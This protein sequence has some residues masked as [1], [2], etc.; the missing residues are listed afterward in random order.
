MGRWRQSCQIHLEN[1]WR[2]PLDMKL[3]WH[4]RSVMCL[5][6][7]IQATMLIWPPRWQTGKFGFNSRPTVTGPPDIK[8][9]SLLCRG[10][11]ISPAWSR[12]VTDGTL[13]FGC[14][15]L[16]QQLSVQRQS[17]LKKQSTDGWKEGGGWGVSCRSLG[18]F[19]K[20]KR[21]IID[22]FFFC[23]SCFYLAINLCNTC[24]EKGLA[25]SLQISGFFCKKLII[26]IFYRRCLSIRSQ[27]YEVLAPIS[28]CVN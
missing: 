6:L 1:C 20:G 28:Y 12:C 22:K 15:L 26:L 24:P 13:D 8:K 21:A 4:G 2:V 23:Q 16:I 9:S 7:S 25:A 11:G 19:Y 17:S 5:G 10:K 18:N 27:S 14:A 3:Q